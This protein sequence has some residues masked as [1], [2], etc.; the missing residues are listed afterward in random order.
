[1]C[2][3]CCVAH[4]GIGGARSQ[5]HALDKLPHLFLAACIAR[6]QLSNGAVDVGLAP[7]DTGAV[8]KQVE[9]VSVVALVVHDLQLDVLIIQIRVEQS[10]VFFSRQVQLSGEEEAGDLLRSEVVA[11]LQLGPGAAV[12]LEVLV[13]DRQIR[14]SSLCS[15]WLELL[16]STYS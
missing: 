12:V 5:H 9:V 14:R 2:L 13:P 4:V 15:L 1:M 10:R 6:G 7:E 3:A 16:L 11:E 8:V